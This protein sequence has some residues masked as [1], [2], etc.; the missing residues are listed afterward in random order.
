MERM[1]WVEWVVVEFES[2]MRNCGRRHPG[3][4]VV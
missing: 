1:E 4:F 2:G 3:F